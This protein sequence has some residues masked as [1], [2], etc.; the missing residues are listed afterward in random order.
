MVRLRRFGSLRLKTWVKAWPRILSVNLR[1]RPTR[2]SFTFRIPGESKSA[3][4][5]DE[6]RQVPAYDH[7]FSDEFKP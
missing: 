5:I 1:N 6:N 7:S 3:E 2:G 4:A